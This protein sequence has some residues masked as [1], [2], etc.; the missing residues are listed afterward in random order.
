MTSLPVPKSRIV[1]HP[2][3]APWSLQ[4]AA[5]FLGVCKE[6]IAIRIADNTIK[7]IRIGRRVLIPDTEVKRLSQAGL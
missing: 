5:D 6:T 1:D 3:G 4:D 2:E 7:R